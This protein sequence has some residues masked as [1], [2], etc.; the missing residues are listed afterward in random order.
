MA[1]SQE[2]NVQPALAGQRSTLYGGCID[3]VLR[4]QGTKLSFAVVWTGED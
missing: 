3:I 4:K 1:S 2:K